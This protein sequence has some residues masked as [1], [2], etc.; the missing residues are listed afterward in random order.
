MYFEVMNQQKRKK[1]IFTK[2]EDDLILNYV[3]K[4]GQNW[5]EIAGMLQ[6]R[7]EKQ[8][9]ERYRT[10]LNPSIRK[11]PWTPEEDNLLIQLYNTYGPKWA[12]LAKHFQGRSDNMLKNRFNY[13]IIKRPRHSK[14]IYPKKVIQENVPSE[15]S[16]VSSPV[17]QEPVETGISIDFEDL[18]SLIDFEQSI[19]E[20]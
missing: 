11:D 17:N 16:A 15:T 10:Y 18:D 8:C 6:G 7:T 19:F 12:E 9:R 4:Y 20:I 1:R 14:N 5:R 3:N 13:H 2:E